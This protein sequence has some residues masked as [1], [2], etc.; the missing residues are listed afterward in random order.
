[1]HGSHRLRKK[2]AEGTA[3]E[4]VPLLFSDVAHEDPPVQSKDFTEFLMRVRRFVCPLDHLNEVVDCDARAVYA[5]FNGFA[6]DLRVDCANKASCDVR[7]EPNRV[8]TATIVP[9]A[10]N[11]I[12]DHAVVMITRDGILRICLV[13]DNSLISVRVGD[14]QDVRRRLATRLPKV[15]GI[16]AEHIAKNVGRCLLELRRLIPPRESHL[17]VGGKKCADAPTVVIPAQ[18]VLNEGRIRS[19]PLANHGNDIWRD[20]VDWT[21]HAE[22]DVGCTDLVLHHDTC[23]NR[24]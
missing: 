4:A 10:F 5:A 19:C 17:M 11:V 7:E 21:F 9:D 23:S 18:I 20:R 8:R 15:D 22:T 24:L 12:V 14:K 2:Y 6:L 1:M 16:V 3:D 13:V